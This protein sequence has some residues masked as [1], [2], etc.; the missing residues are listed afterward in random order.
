M[1]YLLTTFSIPIAYINGQNLAQLAMDDIGVVA[2]TRRELLECILNGEEVLSLIKTPG[3]RFQGPEAPK[4]AAT[5]IQSI[6]RMYLQLKKRHQNFE[7]EALARKIQSLW[8]VSQ[9]QRAFQRTLRTRRHAQ[10][11]AWAQEQT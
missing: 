10:E 7:R 8:C 11:D 3:R 9:T 5:L 6:V 4:I 2:V 1:E